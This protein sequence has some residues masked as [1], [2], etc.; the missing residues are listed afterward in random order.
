M[1]TLTLG[2]TIL[3]VAF[4]DVATHIFLYYI[5]PHL[6]FILAIYHYHLA[7]CSIGIAMGALAS[8]GLYCLTDKVFDYFIKK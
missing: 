2:N 3:A 5:Q 4:V 7:K 6:L 8:Y 1:K